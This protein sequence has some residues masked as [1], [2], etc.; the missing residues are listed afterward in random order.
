[1]T[2]LSLS[3]TCLLEV[4]GE[5]GKKAHAQLQEHVA[6]FPAAMLEYELTRS[7]F[8]LLRSVPPLPLDEQACRQVAQAIKLG[9]QQKLR[10]QERQVILARRWRIAYRALAGVTGLAAALV[11]FASVRITGREAERRQVASAASH[12]MEYLS[13]DAANQT[14]ADLD[15]V[16]RQIGELEDARLSLAAP[17]SI[18]AQSVQD[19]LNINNDEPS[20]MPDEPGSL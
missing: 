15:H 20:G 14:D 2:R 3:Q 1:M 5:L 12:L 10:A 6:K 17:D 16:A 11:I 19:L 7:Q 4:S 8:E 18:S 9:V 13:T